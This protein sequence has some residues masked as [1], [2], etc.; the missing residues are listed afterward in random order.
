MTDTQQTQPEVAEP[1]TPKQWRAF[2]LSR[3][4]D[5]QMQ[6]AEHVIENSRTASECLISNHQAAV[7]EM[8]RLSAILQ[9]LIMVHT[10]VA[11]ALERAADALTGP[12]NVPLADELRQFAA[13]FRAAAGEQS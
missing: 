9:G 2:Y 8:L 6:I 13:D 10:G 1:L 11:D 4:H 7:E 5:Q 3:P 12:E